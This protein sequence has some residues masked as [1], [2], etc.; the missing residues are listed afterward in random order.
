MLLVPVLK[1]CNS[2]DYMYLLPD[3]EWVV[4]PLAVAL[5]VPALV[6]VVLAVPAVVVVVPFVELVLVVVPILV[7]LAV[8]LL[9]EQVQVVLD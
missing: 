4:V 9:L 1:H 8:V 3:L 2:F 5:A 7:V 6:A